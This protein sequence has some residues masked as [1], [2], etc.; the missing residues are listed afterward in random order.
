MTSTGTIGMD[1][2]VTARSMRR[3]AAQPGKVAVTEHWCDV[4]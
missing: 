4:K 3:I 2:L 1:T